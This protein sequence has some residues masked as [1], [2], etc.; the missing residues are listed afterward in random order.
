MGE[1][2]SKIQPK[3]YCL[4]VGKGSWEK[5]KVGKVRV[6]KSEVLSWKVPSGYKIFNEVFKLSKIFQLRL[7]LFNFI[8]FNSISNFPN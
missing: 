5:R 4:G 3:M 1:F 8:F 2:E 7:E 6:E